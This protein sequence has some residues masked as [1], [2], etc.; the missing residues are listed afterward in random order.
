MSHNGMASV[1]VNQNRLKLTGTHQPLVYTDDVN[2]MGASVH[3]VKKNTDAS[4]GASKEP[5][6]R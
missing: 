2:A 5:G 6:L 1:K 3:T 4:I